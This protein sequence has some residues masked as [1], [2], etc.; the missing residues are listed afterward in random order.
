MIVINPGAEEVGRRRGRVPALR[1]FK[2]GHRRV[3]IAQSDV[4]AGVFNYSVNADLR[5]ASIDT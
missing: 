5:A 3:G 2:R 4:Q 1:T